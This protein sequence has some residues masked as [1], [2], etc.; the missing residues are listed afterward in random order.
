MNIHCN[1]SQSRVSLTNCL[2]HLISIF[3][4]MQGQIKIGTWNINGLGK[5]TEKL[6]DDEF[7]VILNQ[8]DILSLLET[9]HTPNTRVSLRGFDSV[10]ITRK[11][12]C[13]K[14]SGLI[15]IVM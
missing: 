11:K 10:A 6:H 5:G 2:V 4:E 3:S 9:W 8:F 13:K 14:G 15:K 1:I 12:V 7:Q